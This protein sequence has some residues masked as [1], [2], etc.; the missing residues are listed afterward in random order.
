MFYLRALT[1]FSLNEFDYFQDIGKLN[2]QIDKHNKKIEK[3]EK[4]KAEI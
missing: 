1:Y 4:K 3:M 2:K